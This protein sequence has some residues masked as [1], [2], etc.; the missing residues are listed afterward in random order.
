[1]LAEAD[2]APDHV[3]I[4]VLA[5]LRYAGQGYQVEAELPRAIVASGDR[6]AIRTAFEAAY[7]RL[8]GRIESTLPV[9]AVGWRVIAS[10]PVPKLD[11]APATAHAGAPH[12]GTRRAWFGDG[13]VE[14]MVIDRATLRAGD[15]LA[16]PALIEEREST[17]VLPPGATARCDVG[18]NLVVAL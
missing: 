9:E 14:A 2:V 16:G 18:L 17:L 4:R 11:L 7:R 3:T 10:G 8:Y 5:A 6:D 12:R 1:M 13:F 15:T